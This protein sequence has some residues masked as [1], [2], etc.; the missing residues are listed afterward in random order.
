MIVY[1]IFESG[2]LVEI[3]STL[4]GANDFITNIITTL[5]GTQGTYTVQAVPV[6]TDT[7]PSTNAQYKAAKGVKK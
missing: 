1:C 4:T 2:R 3:F 6:N 7:A 5:K